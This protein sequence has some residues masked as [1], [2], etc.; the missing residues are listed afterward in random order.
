MLP[1]PTNT[2]VPIEANEAILPAGKP[3]LA[4]VHEV[5]L[6]V[7]KKIPALVPAN[8]LLPFTSIA[9]IYGLV[10]PLFTGVHKVPLFVDIYMPPPYDPAKSVVPLT[11]NDTMS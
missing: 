9:T 6:F 8:K 5:P 1:V 7:D 2:V 4:G 3:V 10:K 11:A